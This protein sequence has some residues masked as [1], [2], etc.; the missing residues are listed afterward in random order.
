VMLL[1]RLRVVENG[2]VLMPRTRPTVCP[3]K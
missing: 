1:N 2:E 3:P